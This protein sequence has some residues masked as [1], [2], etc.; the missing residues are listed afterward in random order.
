MPDKIK[1]IPKAAARRWLR[2]AVLMV[3]VIALGAVLGLVIGTV[4][5][6][7]TWSPEKL[8]GYESTTLYDKNMEAFASLHAEENRIQVP[9]SQIPEDLVNAFVATEDQSFYHHHGVNFTS[10]ARAVL[11]DVVTGSK[12]QG[13]S[14]ITQQ[15]ARNAFLNPEKTWTRKI[16]EIAMAFIL[17]NRYSKNEIMDFY[18]NRIY[19]GSGAWGVQTAAQT[20][21]GKDVNELNLA[22]CSL[23]AGLA[24]RP[25]AYSPFRNYSLAKKRQEVVL[26]RMVDCGYIT[27]KE[28]ATAAREPLHFKKSVAVKNQY[29]YFTDYVIDETDR[30]LEDEGL[31]DNPQNAIFKGGLKI[32]TTMDPDIQQQAEEVYSNPSSFPAG[33]SKS[34]Q[35][36]QSAMAVVENKTGAVRAVIGGRAYVQ[37]RGFNRAVD[38]LRQPGSAFKPLVVYGPAL[39][40]GYTPDYVL[41]DSPVTFTFGGQTWSPKNY[42]G[43]YRG[44]ITMRTAVQYSVNIYAVKLAAQV[45]ISNGIRFAE[46]L[47]IDTLVKTGR[48]NDYN[49]STALGGITRGV[50]PLE[51]ASA[52]SAFGN[53]GIHAPHFVISKILDSSGNTIYEYHPRYNKA[54]SS[55]TAW[56][57]TGML[58]GVVQYGTG[59]KAKIPGVSCAGKTG[60]T[61]DDK[62]AWFVGYTP[63]YSCAVWMGYDRKET[64][65]R[66]FGGSYPA[67]IWK[68][69][70]SRASYG[71][72]NLNF[73]VPQDITQTAICSKSGKLAS[74]ACPENDIVLKYFSPGKAPTETCDLHVLVQVCSESGLLATPNCPNPVERGFLKNAPPGDPEAMPTQYCNL[75]GGNAVPETTKVLVCQ[76]PRNQGKQYLANIPPKGQSGGCPPGFIQEVE[77][78]VNTHLDPCPLPDH[79]L[80]GP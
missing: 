14:T 21:F 15:L 7:P 17:E 75:H 79:Q 45:G 56:L 24:Q 44:N 28:S 32:Y 63:D 67:L 46:S 65:S 48:S 26:A 47:G 40:A 16:K 38:A 51:M 73:S 1:K 74:P 25:N 70:M 60:T 54:M 58:Q 27:L 2:A 57:M 72:Q 33:K 22:E 18:L 36:I 49:L 61:Q 35:T 31:F 39:E 71:R 59:T 42:D 52:Y 41:A 12:A 23:L 78:P 66:T 11:V 13:A 69:I 29:G 9:L 10:I 37:Q 34:G 43:T 6:V 20:Y 62:D 4:V 5:N 50:S 55:E 77:V 68:S 76:D 64:M 80:S 3:L 8:S 30:I 19:F 53:E